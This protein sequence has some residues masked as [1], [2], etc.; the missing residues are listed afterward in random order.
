M[1]YKITRP[2]ACHCNSNSVKHIRVKKTKSS[3]IH[4]GI[5]FAQFLATVFA[6]LRDVAVWRPG[7]VFH[8]LANWF[9]GRIGYPGTGG[10]IF[11]ETADLKT[12]WQVDTST[13]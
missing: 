4:R 11:F 8:T 2:K 10:L 6:L 1:L 3:Y 12:L 13:G 5:V 9:E 7:T